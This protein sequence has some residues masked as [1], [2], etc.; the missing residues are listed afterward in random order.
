MAVAIEDITNRQELKGF[1]EQFVPGEQ[2]IGPWTDLPAL[3]SGWTGTAYYR[4]D[5]STGVVEFRGALNPG[6]TA[7]GTLLFTMPL[8]PVSECVF[9]CLHAGAGSAGNATSWLK[10]RTDGT[11]TLFFA[12]AT[13]GGL[14]LAP[15][16]YPTF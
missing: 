11:V 13:I 3:Q 1:I 12:G 7:D 9:V 5:P 16:R 14:N 2:S 6:T 15:V 8:T 4:I 10:I